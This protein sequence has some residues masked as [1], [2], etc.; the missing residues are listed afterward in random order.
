MRWRQDSDENIRHDFIEFMGCGKMDFCSSLLFVYEWRRY[1]LHSMIFFKETNT[2]YTYLS[3]I[4]CSV[5]KYGHLW[6]QIPIE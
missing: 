2:I 6:A 3:H 1:L 5:I 4:L